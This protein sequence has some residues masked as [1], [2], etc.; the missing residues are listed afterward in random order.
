MNCIEGYEKNNALS[1]SYACEADGKWHGEKIVCIPK[2][3]GSPPKVNNRLGTIKPI[4]QQ[5]Y[6]QI[7]RDKQG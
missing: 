7:D 2:D 3:C 4:L 1:G 6:I 5:N